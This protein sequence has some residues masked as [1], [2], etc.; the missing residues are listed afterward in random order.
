MKFNK[1][2]FWGWTSCLD[3]FGGMEL[4]SERPRRTLALEVL[5]PFKDL[6]V[7][8]NKGTKQKVSRNSHR[9]CARLPPLRFS[10][11]VPPLRAFGPYCC[12]YMSSSLLRH[13]EG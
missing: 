12:R 3:F 11:Q 10:S 2:K 5:T 8:N 6:Y 13:H 4:G 1:L 9:C 7:R